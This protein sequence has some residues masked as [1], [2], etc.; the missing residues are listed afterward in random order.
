M[1]DRPVVMYWCAQGH[2]VGSTRD[3]E[4]TP[5]P[6][7]GCDAPEL[8][9]GE[10]DLTTR[11]RNQRREL[12]RLNDDVERLRKRLGDALDEVWLWR[13]HTGDISDPSV[14]TLTVGQWL[15]DDDA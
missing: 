12:A 2:W 7:P 14:E 5:C 6:W 11:I 15:E 10:T 8:P 4:G 9:A 13:V 1:S 3:L